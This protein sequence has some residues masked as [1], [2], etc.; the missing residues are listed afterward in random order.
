MKR[1]FALLLSL[2]LALSL[3]AC[4]KPVSD[5]PSGSPSESNTGEPSPEPT[6]AYVSEYTQT[7]AGLDADTVMFTVDGVDVTAEFFF[8][9]LAYDCYMVDMDYQMYLGQSINFEDQAQDGKTTAEYLKDDARKMATAYLLLEKEAA[10]RGAD[11]TQEQL[12]ML[13]EQKAALI[14]QRGLDGF[15][16][17]L[18]QQGL[19][20]QTYDRLN[21]LSGPLAENLLATIPDPTEEEAEAFRTENEI[22]GAK[23]ILLLSASVDASGEVVLSSSGETAKNEDGTNFTGTAEEYNAAM[24]EKLEGLLAEIDAAEDPI[25][26]FDELMNQYSEDPGLSASPD[27]YTFTPSTNF[28]EEFKNAVYDLEPGEHSGIV[29]TEHGYHILLRTRPDITQEYRRQKLGEMMEEWANLE[30]T[31]A[32]AYE[33]L[34]VKDFYEKY[35]A[36]AKQFIDEPA[37]ADSTAPTDPSSESPSGST[38]G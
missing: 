25:A 19:S 14:D 28:V 4:G 10:A 34:D 33:A 11:A 24:K 7:V 38:G 3:C 6:P 18:K 29:E 22:Y 2:V 5:G 23:H 37:P 32:P 26:K 31:A 30:F 36:Y 1:M 27:G 17:L 8:Y 20:E 35:T 15:K 16:D 12:D 21:L 13:K 9:W